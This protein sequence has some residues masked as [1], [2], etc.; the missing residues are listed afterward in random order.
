MLEVDVDISDFELNNDMITVPIPLEEYY[1]TKK[2]VSVNLLLNPS[3]LC[4]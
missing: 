4:S 1:I 3:L 2:I